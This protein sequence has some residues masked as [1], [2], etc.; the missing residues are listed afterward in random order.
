MREYLTFVSNTPSVLPS[1]LVKARSRRD[2]GELAHL[3]ESVSSQRYLGGTSAASRLYLGRFSALFSSSIARLTSRRCTCSTC[4]YRSYLPTYLLS[5]FIARVLACLLTD[6]LL[7]YALTHSRY[8]STYST[9]T[10]WCACVTSR[11]P[12]A[13]AA[14]RTRTKRC[15]CCLG[16]CCCGCCCF[17]RGTPRAV[18]VAVL[19][20]H[21]ARRVLLLWLLL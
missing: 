1:V 14:A 2:L 20:L 3:A 6:L 19:V 11:G 8:R 9:A 5:F 15:R 17:T 13:T 7:T 18:V 16:C 12:S 21:V 10:T 4:S